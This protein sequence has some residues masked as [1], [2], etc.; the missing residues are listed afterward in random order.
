MLYILLS[1]GP[2]LGKRRRVAVGNPPY[3]AGAGYNG[4]SYCTIF[5]V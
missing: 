5:F 2:E 3:T 4:I 1:V